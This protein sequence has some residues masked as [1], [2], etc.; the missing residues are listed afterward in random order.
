M[1][2]YVVGTHQ[3]SLGMAL[4]STHSIC[5]YGELE[6]IILELSSNLNNLLK[7][8]DQSDIQEF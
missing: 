6:K 7:W 1:K 3:K 8:K 4:N 5:F 2:I